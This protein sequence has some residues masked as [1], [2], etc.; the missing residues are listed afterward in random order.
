VRGW[1]AVII[2]VASFA[3]SLAMMRQVIGVASPWYGLLLMCCVLGVIG[4]GRPLFVVPLPRFIR[5]SYAWETSATYR[6]L[7]V[8]AFGK[9][10]TRTPLRYLNPLVY[11]GPD[12]ELSS[13]IAQVDSAEAAHYLAALVLVP[14]LFIAHSKGDIGGA[15]VLWAMLIL[16]NLYPA[17]H[18]RWTRER[19][20]RFARRHEGVTRTA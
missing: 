10:L 12:R 17:L 13:V 1:I 14:Y 2:T 20:V 15:I 19:L 6:K 9:L 4:I 18:L 7:G 3:F 5:Q 11:L 16:G 8:L